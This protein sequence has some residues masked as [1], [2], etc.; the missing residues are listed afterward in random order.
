M[1][2]KILLP[3]DAQILNIMETSFFQRAGF[4]FI[5]VADDED[6][7]HKIEEQDPALVILDIE[8]VDV[9][10]SG[11][12][13]RVKDDSLLSKTQILI[14]VPSE[15]RQSSEEYKCLAADAI[16]GR[17]IDVQR[18][19]TSASHLL[20]I[21][22]RAPPR[23]E[24]F[25]MVSCGSDIDELHHGW[26]RNIN[27][28]GAFIE[29]RELM[30]VDYRLYIQFSLE[31]GGDLIGGKAR[32]AWVNHPEWIKCEHLPTGMGVQFLDLDEED[33]KLISDFVDAQISKEE[34][35]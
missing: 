7:F 15:S 17:P 13:R 21:F 24:T 20:E 27:A 12:C 33:K 26:I 4:E 34:S 19:L 23:I 25:I 6:I 31:E 2:K 35:A 14:V 18:F 9:D 5:T 29:T 8:K 22:H 11:L 28:G 10:A 1:S 32:V 3:D 30:P 16:V